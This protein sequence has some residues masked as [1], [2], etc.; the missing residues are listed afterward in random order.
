[1]LASDACSRPPTTIKSHNLHASDIRGAMGEI[2]SYH[3]KDWL[4]PYLWALQAVCLLAFLWPL[5][6]C[7]PWDGSGHHSFKNK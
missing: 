2:A 1:M 5:A 7:F 6:F 4:S 3:K